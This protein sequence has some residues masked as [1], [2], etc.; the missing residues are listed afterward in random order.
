MSLNEASET[1]IKMTSLSKDWTIIFA[2][3]LVVLTIFYGIYAAL[4]ISRRSVQ[5]LQFR[6][7]LLLGFTH[8]GLALSSLFV[9]IFLLFETDGIEANYD[10]ACNQFDWIL[11]TSDYLIIAPYIVRAIRVILIFTPRPIVDNDHDTIAF[12]ASVNAQGLNDPLMREQQ[13]IARTSTRL[14]H[15]SLTTFQLLKPLIAAFIILSGVKVALYFFH[16]NTTHGFGCVSSSTEV[17]DIVQAITLLLLLYVLHRLRQVKDEIRD[18]FG[19][20]KEYTAI[21]YIWLVYWIAT[22]IL[23]IVR[24]GSVLNHLTGSPALVSV[25]DSRLIHA[26]ILLVCNLCM[27][28]A[29]ISHA[30]YL[31]YSQSFS[32]LWS[33]PDSL[34][35]IDSLLKDIICIQHF[36]AYLATRHRVQ[37][38]L[39]W[40]EIELL[41]D[42]YEHILSSAMIGF[43]YS[44]QYVPDDSISAFDESAD[45][46]HLSGSPQQRSLGWYRMSDS[47]RLA[48]RQESQRIFDRY[49]H[50]QSP[51]NVG[52]SAVTL[53]KVTRDLSGDSISITCFDEVQ[54]EL[55]ER[56]HSELAGFLDSRECQRCWQE[57]NREEQLRDALQKSGMI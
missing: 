56:M 23:G 17:W 36:R 53:H 49:L 54:A 47:A 33:S 43:D 45:S 21:S 8:L 27:T 57:L 51:T 38:V 29:S 7:P 34:L 44:Q 30:I 14:S 26:P 28:F 31:S 37:L 39:A 6:G 9:V 22:F 50:T 4:L 25:E 15:P 2:C 52:L 46:M 41:K 55:Y 11:W 32:P 19:Q 13:S 42:F 24:E 18:D 20:L 40:V 12:T 16:I 3:L 1:T 10:I 5:P 48:I 35:N